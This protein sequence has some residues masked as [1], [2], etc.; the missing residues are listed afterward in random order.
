MSNILPTNEINH[1]KELNFIFPG[2]NKYNGEVLFK[3]EA[4]L[5]EN[6]DDD[7]DGRY[8]GKCE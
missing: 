6:D 5:L 1:R 3:V 4:A 7:E 8:E 2:R